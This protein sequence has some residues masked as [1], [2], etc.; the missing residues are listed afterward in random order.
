MENCLKD[1]IHKNIHEF[2]LTMIIIDTNQ[3]KKNVNIRGNT[4]SGG[5]DDDS[6]SIIKFTMN[7]TTTLVVTDIER[8]PRGITIKRVE[9][10]ENEQQPEHEQQQITM[11]TRHN[12]GIIRTYI[13]FIQFNELSTFLR[14]LVKIYEFN[15]RGNFIISLMDDTPP[16]PLTST[17]NGTDTD[18]DTPLQSQK[19]NNR[20]KKMSNLKKTIQILWQHFI[21]N[22]LI[23]YDNDNDVSDDDNNRS[24]NDNNKCDI[25][26]WFPYD[27]K[28]NCGDNVENYVKIDEV[29]I[30]T[31][32]SNK[33]LNVARWQQQKTF[34]SIFY[35]I[36]N[37]YHVFE[38]KTSPLTVESIQQSHHQPE[39]Q[40]INPKS[41]YFFNKIPND[42]LGCPIK[43]LLVIWPPFVTPKTS[44]WYGLEHKLFLDI[45]RFM[46]FR[47]I[48]IYTNNSAITVED[49]Q[50]NPSNPHLIFGNFYPSIEKHEKL[51]YSIAYLYDYIDW[52]VPKAKLQPLWMNIIVAFRPELWA[53]IIGVGIT[54]TLLYRQIG[55]RLN[56]EILNHRNINYGLDSIRIAFGISIMKFPK[57]SIVR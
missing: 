28:S 11:R 48:E 21:Y 43:A 26:T 53:I 47:I 49:F 50:Q 4:N 38:Y 12:L 30:S 36:K 45:S 14:K 32:N 31:T 22:F 34:Q 24:N 29:V 6:D 56:N 52:V 39:R 9:G 44:P 3:I 2:D 57:S 1:I 33:S 15:S 35:G 5:N 46:N 18:T 20:N 55:H 54:F 23:L 51:D 16:P 37:P 41:P 13:L 17:L 19:K 10:D 42:L 25:I 7:R 8:Y 40:L 27:Q